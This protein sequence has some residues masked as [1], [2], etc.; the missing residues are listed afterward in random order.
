MFPRGS[1]VPCRW[2]LKGVVRRPSRS[3]GM[4][5]Q[6]RVEGD[7]AVKKPHGRPV[8][9]AGSVLG[10]SREGQE[11]H[12]RPVCQAGSVFG[13]RNSRTRT[14]RSSSMPGWIRV[15]GKKGRETIPT[16]VQYVGLDPYWGKKGREKD[17]TVVRCGG[18]DPYK[19]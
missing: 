6:I 19:G 18:P 9:Q 12:G 13:E 4:G 8:C 10:E 17:P 3:S 7:G 11:P 5:C 1:G 15:R 16:V 2:C 14:P